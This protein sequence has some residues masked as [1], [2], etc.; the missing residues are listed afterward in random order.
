[1]KEKG[2]GKDS[3]VVIHDEH[4]GRLRRSAQAYDTRVA[5]IV[6]GADGIK[7][8]L[9][10]KQEGLVDKSQNVALTDLG[11]NA[12]VPWESGFSIMGNLAPIN[13]RNRH[14]LR[15]TDGLPGR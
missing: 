1:M 4:L 6:R 12:G 10:L 13:G 5:G 11:A 8:G 15:S 14:V 2:I 3:V 9:A 7:A